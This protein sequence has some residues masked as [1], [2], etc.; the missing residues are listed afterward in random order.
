MRDQFT[1]ITDRS[2]VGDGIDLKLREFKIDVRAALDL[3]ETNLQVGGV[4]DGGIIAAKL[5]DNAVITSKIADNAVT[6]NK[7]AAGA[8]G[9]T[10]IADSA[11]TT[12]KLAANSIVPSKLGTI[13]DQ[14]TLDQGGASNTLRVIKPSVLKFSGGYQGTIDS[15]DTGFFL[16]EGTANT[17]QYGTG[18]VTVKPFACAPHPSIL[19]APRLLQARLW[20]KG[21][22]T[23]ALTINVF[24]NG[25]ALPT[26]HIVVPVADYSTTPSVFELVETGSP[27]VSLPWAMADTDAVFMTISTGGAISGGFLLWQVYIG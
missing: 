17:K 26:G 11:V 9:T 6:T 13:T 20:V 18:L 12:L 4:V 23:A 21:N 27:A 16:W 10:D 15:G 14:V 2:E 8:V 5:A 25:T 7:I 19:A 3:I 1:G 22:V 24:T